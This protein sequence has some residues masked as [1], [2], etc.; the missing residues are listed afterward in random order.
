MR[1]AGGVVAVVLIAAAQAAVADTLR[2]H[3]NVPSRPA[4]SAVG[5]AP[6]PLD[7]GATRAVDECEPS[8]EPVSDGRSSVSPARAARSRLR[9]VVVGAESDLG[10]SGQ[11]AM[12]PVRRAVVSTPI[13]PAV[14]DPLPSAGRVILFCCF[15]C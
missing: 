12:P 8:H 1:V 3:P 15:T 9:E 7:S 6:A 5:H 11:F 10:H 13:R 4:A 14:P 2:G